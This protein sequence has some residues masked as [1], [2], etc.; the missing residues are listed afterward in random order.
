[1]EIK[2]ILAKVISFVFHPLMLPSYLL[3]VIYQMSLPEVLAVSLKYKMFL[4][5][6][7]FSMTF[8]LPVLL[9]LIL[10]NMKLIKHFQMQ[11]RVERIISLAA[12]FVFYFFTFY[13]LRKLPVFPYYNLFLEGSAILV[14]LAIVIN[15]F[16]KISLHL[17]AWGGITAALVGMSLQFHQALY[18]WLFDVIFISGLVGFARL[19]CKAH[20]TS[21]IYFGFVTGFVVMLGIFLL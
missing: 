2:T 16:Y 18:F 11:L 19:Q 14:L 8:L 17:I 10:W 21:Q 13:A 1:M 20:K 3:L 12:M 7:V 9:V 6:F 4:L 15:Y 5:V